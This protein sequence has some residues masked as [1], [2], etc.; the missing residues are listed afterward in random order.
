MKGFFCA[1][2]EGEGG[3]N[4]GIWAGFGAVSGW[5]GAFCA[6]FGLCNF[7]TSFAKFLWCKDLGVKIWLRLGSFLK[8]RFLHPGSYR[9]AT[10]VTEDT[11]KQPLKPQISLIFTDFILFLSNRD[12]DWTG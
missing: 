10:E 2:N 6:V 3:E 9:Y 4:A 1:P 8:T 11:E 12:A 7:L 5:F